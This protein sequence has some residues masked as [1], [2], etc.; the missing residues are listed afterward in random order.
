MNWGRLIVKQS[1]LVL[2]GLALVVAVT[3]CGGGGP[4]NVPSDDVAG[5]GD[6]QGSKGDWDALMAQKKQNYTATKQPLPKGGSGE[7]PNPRPNVTP[8]LV[9]AGE[10]EQ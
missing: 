1:I 3:A 6:G 4:P 9:S 10:E 2:F 5:V 8:V 7:P